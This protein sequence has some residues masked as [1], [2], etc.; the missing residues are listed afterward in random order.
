MLG[1]VRRRRGGEEGGREE[2]G[3]EE[4]GGEEEGREPRKMSLGMKEETVSSA[5]GCLNWSKWRKEGEEGGGE[6]KE[7]RE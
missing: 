5:E 4:E 3:R 7:G 6:K 1:P 2:E